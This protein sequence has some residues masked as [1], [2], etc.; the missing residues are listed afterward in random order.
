MKTSA[1]HP[2]P[3]QLKIPQ[4][5]NCDKL[6]IIAYFQQ[7]WHIEND[8]FKSIIDEDIFYKNPDKLRN[9]LIF[10]VGH[11]AVFYINKL[12]MAGWEIKRINPDY[13]KIFD[14]G[15]DPEYPEE[16]VKIINKL[17]Q[18]SLKNLENYR[19]QVYEIIINLIENTALDLPIT[20]HSKWWAIIMGIEHQRIHIE[21]SSM[22]LRQLPLEA[23]K[24]PSHWDYCPSMGKPPQREMIKVDGGKVNLGITLDHPFYGWDVDYGSQE[25][26]V[27]PFRVSKYMVTNGEFLDFVR[28]KG[29]ES[30]KFWSV[31]AWKWLNGENRHHPKF[32]RCEGQCYRYRAL[33]HEFDLP[34]DYPAE[35]NHHEAMAF[36]RYQEAKTGEKYQLMSEAQWHLA[37]A[38][39]DDSLTNYN[40]NLRYHSPHPVAEGAVSNS[41]IVD[42]RGNV[43]EWLG[44]TFTP[45]SGFTP[46]YLYED[47]SAPFFDNRHYLLVGG[48]WITNG[49]ESLPFYRNWFRPHFYQHAGFRLV[50]N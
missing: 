41:G 16:L 47:Y 46:H 4:L 2:V 37:R 14:M 17:R 30:P 39:D 36:L 9:P 20:P 48:A 8:L 15:V 3:N 44:D 10:Y 23:L 33:F 45:L 42:L 19:Q 6:E 32:W 50:Q 22:L 38:K 12:V 29:Y 40:L 11:S 18:F 5:N 28:D 1:L 24:A 43:W 35:V 27:K 13:E 7:A 26:E 21:T 25:V 49:T 31:E 34:L